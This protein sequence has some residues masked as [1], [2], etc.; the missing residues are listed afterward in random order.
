MAVMMRMDWAD[1][2]QEQYDK[3]RQVVNWEG[4]HPKGGM[5]HLAAFDESGAHITDAWESA[6]DFQRFTE[7]RLMPGIAEVGITGQPQIS[8]LPLHS[9]FAPAYE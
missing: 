3:L 2:T 7:D 6:E 8:L 5:I 9:V 1:A 4:D